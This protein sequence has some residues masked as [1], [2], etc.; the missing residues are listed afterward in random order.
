MALQPY[1]SD[2]FTNSSGV[3]RVLDWVVRTFHS[4]IN[5]SCIIGEYCLPKY[6]HFLKLIPER[7][8]IYA[9]ERPILKLIFIGFLMLPSHV[10]LKSNYIKFRSFQRGIVWLCRS[11]GCQTTIPQSLARKYCFSGLALAQLGRAAAASAAL[12]QTFEFEAATFD[13]W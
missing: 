3:F 7:S 8:A 10:Y 12:R 9:I 2:I 13:R 4:S 5:T 11:K 6:L 1:N